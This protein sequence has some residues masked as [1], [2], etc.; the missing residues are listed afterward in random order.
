VFFVTRA[1]AFLLPLPLV[2]LIGLFGLA[3]VMDGSIGVAMRSLIASYEVPEQALSMVFFEA[4]GSLGQMLG[5]VFAGIALAIGGYP[6]IGL[7]M[8]MLCVLAAWLP[9]VSGRLA[10]R[11]PPAPAGA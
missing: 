5:G 10:W 6:A 3:S 7:L 1:T 4:C 11:A 2:V 8:G 9:L